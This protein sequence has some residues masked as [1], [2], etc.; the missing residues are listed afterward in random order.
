M[1]RVPDQDLRGFFV[2]PQAPEEAA[3]YTYGTPEGGAG[4][5]AHPRML[6]FIILL[7]HKW[8]VADDRKI[9]IGNVSLFGGAKPRDHQGHKSGLEVDIRAL[10]KDGRQIPVSHTDRYYDQTATRRMVEVMWQTGMV[11]RIFFNDMTIPR[12]Q[13]R[14]DHDNHLHV[15]VIA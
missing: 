4:Q 3:Y 12:V 13:R 9:G 1:E 10:R 11:T 5:Y 8:G 7:E 6:T 15:E 14:V 2:L